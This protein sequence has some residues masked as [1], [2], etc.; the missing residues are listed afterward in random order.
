MRDDNKGFT[1]VELAV[2]MAIVAVM[3]VGTFVA[4]RYLLST[5]A[6]KMG[7]SIV[8]SLNTARINTM[9]YSDS[10]V[11]EISM[12]SSDHAYVRVYRNATVDES[13]GTIVCTTLID[14]VDLGRRVEDISFDIGGNVTSVSKSSYANKLVFNFKKSTGGFSLVPKLGVGTD[15]MSVGRSYGIITV[16]SSSGKACD[17]KLYFLTG[18]VELL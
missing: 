6:K 12:D 11:C 8:S 15:A 13:T 18:K 16:T 17:V 9:A 4:Q 2:V 7:E 10:W 1:L 5:D 14:E 3:M